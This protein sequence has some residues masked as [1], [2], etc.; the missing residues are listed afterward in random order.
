MRLREEQFQCN[1]TAP[2][3]FLCG[4]TP[5]RSLYHSGPKSEVKS[6]VDWL[7]S[8]QAIAVKERGHV[9]DRKGADV[10]SERVSDSQSRSSQARSSY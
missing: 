3:I 2:I 8:A 1:I 4:Y 10:R 7:D 6:P 5:L 9:T